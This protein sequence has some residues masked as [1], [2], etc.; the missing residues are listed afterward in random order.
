MHTQT[1]VDTWW[2]IFFKDYVILKVNEVAL[3]V[4]FLITKMNFLPRLDNL[5]F[6]ILIQY[7]TQQ[8]TKDK[9]THITV[10]C[11]QRKV[12]FCTKYFMTPL[13]EKHYI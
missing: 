10:T 11:M 12:I 5:D 2:R 13:N 8:S 4:L 6:D 3:I 7:T 1:N 9:V